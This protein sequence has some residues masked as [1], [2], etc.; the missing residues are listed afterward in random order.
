MSKTLEA[1]KEEILNKSIAVLG[2]GVSNRPVIE[3]LCGLG[4]KVTGF[5]KSSRD[6][7]G[8][9][10][11][12][13]EKVG[14]SLV[15]GENYLSFLSGYDIIFKTPGIR[16]DIP[17]LIK[18]V[19]EGAK[20]TSEM[21]VF[22]DLC[23]AKIFAV[24]GSDGKTTTT[25]IIYKMLIEEGYNCWLGGNIGTP[26]LDKIENINKDDYVILEL[27]SFQ[28]QTIKKSP[29]IAVITNIS[30]NHLDVHNSMDEYIEAKK[31]IFRYQ[32]AGNRL[33][34]NYDNMITRGFGNTAKGEVIYFSRREV[35]NNGV[36]IEDKYLTYKKKILFMHAIERDSIV[37]PG[38]HNVENYLAAMAAVWGYVKIENIKKVAQEFRGVEHRIELVREYNGVK[39][40]NDSI[41]S[42]PTRTKASLN[43]FNSKLI[44]IAGG[45]D[46]KIPYDLMGEVIFRKVKKLILMGKTGHKIKKAYTK[47]C[48][49]NSIPTNISIFYADSME[50]AVAISNNVSD[51]GD[52]VIL[53]PASA[54]FDMY[55]NFEERGNHFKSIVRKL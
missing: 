42:S 45:Y 27:S 55:K 53:S 28:L 44:L 7:L 26:L 43:A 17:E 15:L 33:I 52:I 30:P 32:K 37:I 40:Y 12:E 20:L 5:D 31:N 50:E 34:L 9:A 3:F 51:Y 48:N 54:S 10:A 6:N 11:D 29:D 23:P 8:K 4:A 18:A 16:H 14:A 2:L 13:M 1:F 39:Y 19:N 46:K 21:E 41:G 22:I 35:L 38:L 47:Y 36:F 24:T 25:T 49:D